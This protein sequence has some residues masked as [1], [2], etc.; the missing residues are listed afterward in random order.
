M[1]NI[2]QTGR[3]KNFKLGTQMEHIFVLHLTTVKGH[4]GKVS[5]KVIQAN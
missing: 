3:P 2:F 5:F 4:G 1:H